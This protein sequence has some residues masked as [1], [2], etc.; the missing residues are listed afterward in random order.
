LKYLVFGEYY[1]EKVILQKRAVEIESEE[2]A[3]SVIH[4][5]GPHI[6]RCACI[7]QDCLECIETIEFGN[8]FNQELKIVDCV[9]SIKFGDR[10]NQKLENL[11]DCIEKI[12][13]GKHFN[14]EINDLP[15]SIVE[16]VLPEDYSKEITRLPASLKRLCVYKNNH[17]Y[18]LFDLRS[19]IMQLLFFGVFLSPIF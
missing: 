15:D 2:D 12:E 10:F 17:Y 3:E 5:F 8:Y 9:K 13:F 6:P 1:N 16:L 14:Q 19:L 18:A 11:P 4:P 7:K